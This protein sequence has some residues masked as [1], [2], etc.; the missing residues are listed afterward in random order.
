VLRFLN[1][2]HPFRVLVSLFVTHLKLYYSL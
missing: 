2:L 1:V